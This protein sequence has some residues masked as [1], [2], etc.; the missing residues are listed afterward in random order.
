MRR[1]ETVSLLVG[2][3]LGLLAFG[4]VYKPTALGFLAA[5][6]G[7]LILLAA[8]LMSIWRLPQ[9]SIARDAW[10][11]LGFGLVISP[12]SILIFGWDSL[13]AS[14][15][16]PLFI[17]SIVWLSPILCIDH[18]RTAHLR[19]GIAL[20][21]SICALGYLTADLLPSLLPA[22][23]KDLVFGGGYEIYYDSRP[24]AFMTETSHFATLVG[25]YAMVWFLLSEAGRRYSAF[26]HLAFMIMLASILVTIGSKGAAISVAVALLTVGFGSKRWSYLAL[27]VVPG[28]F[29]AEAQVAAIAFDIENFT[30][31]ST[32]LGL[33]IAGIAAMAVNP[34]GYGYYGFYGVMRYFGAWSMEFLSDMPLLFTELR[35]IVEELTSV[36]FKTSIFDFGIVFGLPFWILLFRLARR[37]DLS[38]PRAR[39]GLAYFFVS[40]LSTSGHES[41]SFFLGLAALLLYF[42]RRHLVSITAVAPVPEHKT[43]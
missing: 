13:F 12:F 8:T 21:L 9:R 10:L 40:G 37:V 39:V 11:L 36:S 32:R 20:G 28:W 2:C 38:D 7:V 14:K 4:S 41:I 30:S 23:A 17:L 22:S 33:W 43:V 6:P 42:P 25:R 26:R 18:L 31:T 34:L 24:R 15:V 29:V 3:G 35:T 19:F 16:I 5:S 1:S 27:L